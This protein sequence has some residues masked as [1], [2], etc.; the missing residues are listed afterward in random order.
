MKIIVF[1]FFCF[2]AFVS[3]SF[4]Q[5]Q[6]DYVEQRLGVNRDQARLITVRLLLVAD[7]CAK[8]IE[9]IASSNITNIVKDSLEKVFYNKYGSRQTIIYRQNKLDTRKLTSSTAKEYFA[10]LRTVGKT[11]D[12]LITFSEMEYGEVGFIKAEN[13]IVQAEA[14]MFF[15]Q[16]YVRTTKKVSLETE[17][18]ELYKDRTGKMFHYTIVYDANTN[19]VD[20]R[21]KEI[22]VEEWAV[23]MYKPKKSV[24][25]PQN[26]Q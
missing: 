23:P 4:A 14:T 18:Q 26:K 24:P 20:I 21:L 5:N 12:L 2:L 1:S 16:T 8:I 7:S 25:K 6:V 17:T 13:G 15:M 9:A 10:H 3:N 11:N 22:T 19:S